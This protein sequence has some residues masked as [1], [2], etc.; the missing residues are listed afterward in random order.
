LAEAPNA[1]GGVSWPDTNRILY[2]PTPSVGIW[3]VSPSGGEPRK[4]TE[5]NVAEG[6][7]SHVWPC[8]VPGTS[9]LLYAA[10]IDAAD[11]FDAAKLY[12]VD[13][14]SGKRTLL[15]DGGSDPSVVGDTLY[16]TRAGTVYEASYDR[17]RQ[18]L[19]GS[20]K[21]L[22]AGVTYAT[23]TGAAQFAAARDTRLFLRGSHGWDLFQPV[24]VGRDGKEP[25]ALAK[26]HRAT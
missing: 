15:V 6:E 7:A 25:V 17:E 9:T 22:Y 5:P 24:V 13:L 20:P 23:A 16:Y 18:A 3:E 10:E 2:S 12:A 4:L 21:P 8:L 11:S 1:L 19:R 26:A 14:A